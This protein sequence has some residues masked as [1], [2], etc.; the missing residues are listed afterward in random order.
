MWRKI[1]EIYNFIPD[2]CVGYT[3]DTCSRQCASTNRV[4]ELFTD[5]AC[6]LSLRC[7]C[8]CGEFNK[9]S[10][11]TQCNERGMIMLPGATNKYDCLDCKCTCPVFQ[12]SVCESQ[13]NAKSK[14]PIKDAKD[15]QGCPI[16]QCDCL[17][18]DCSAECHG[19]SFS[20]EYGDPNCIV[21][22]KCICPKLD[23]DTRCRGKRKRHGEQKRQ[24]G[25]SS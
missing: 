13:C 20:E 1:R 6:Q 12:E 22:C 9:T 4:G 17:S 14:A 21:G 24:D 8:H 7:S 23:C 25:L 18:R 11:I 15:I 2:I 3:E 19:Y 10:C 5:L 16:C